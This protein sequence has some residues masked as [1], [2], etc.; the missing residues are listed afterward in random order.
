MQFLEII[1]R[2][3][4]FIPYL[5]G[6]HVIVFTDH[7]ALKNL[8]EKSDANPRLIRWITLLQEL[9]YEIKDRMGF[10]RPV[11]NNFS[12]VVIDGVLRGLYL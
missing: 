12:T 4:T 6:S 10:E 3:E 11:V 8:I 2:F 1:I 5:T 7:A 9:D